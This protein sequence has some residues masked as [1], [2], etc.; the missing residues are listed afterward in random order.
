[1]VGN[2]FSDMQFGKNAGMYTVFVKTTSPDVELPHPDIDLLY[3]SLADFAKG[4]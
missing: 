3:N 4:L 1:M 2:N